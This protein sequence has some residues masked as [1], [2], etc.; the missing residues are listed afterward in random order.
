MSHTEHKTPF[1]ALREAIRRVVLPLVQASVRRARRSKVVRDGD[2]GS[3]TAFAAL[4]REV[5]ARGLL[6]P[7]PLF[8][9]TRIGAVLSLHAGAA[10]WVSRS[11]G[12]A[13]AF[14]AAPV[15]AFTSG[16]LVLLAHDAAHRAVFAGRRAN[17][18]LALFLINVLN[19]GS[20]GWW[21]AS[22]NEHHAR[23]NDRDLDPD[24]D[25]PVLALSEEQAAQ[26]DPGSHPWIARQHYLAFILMGFVGLTMRVYS[27]IWLLRRRHAG[28]V[29]AALVYYVV[30]PPFLAATLGIGRGVAFLIVQQVLFGLY[31]GSITAVNHWGMPLPAHTEELDF[32]RHQVTTSR[33][34]SGPLSDLWF[35]G[36]NRQ[37]E[38]HLFPS[39][40][41][42]NLS[43]ARPLVR[44]LCAARGLPYHEV[45]LLQAYREVF[46]TLRR[47]AGSVRSPRAGQ[48]PL[49]TVPEERCL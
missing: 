20:R 12:S 39:M 42:N 28:E 11:G 30:Y 10:L 37:I 6:K 22:H 27:A 25:Y 43:K 2:H 19:G 33:N 16:Q 24:I 21:T 13:L 15:L 40:P 5:K 36:L 26:K 14:I 3:P 41:R 8:Y 29:A 44:E 34:V 35:G 4:K 32:V 45:G 1:A 7:Q 17:D 31:L 38:H 48:A 49:D 23:S 18:A 47:V 9:A 46:T